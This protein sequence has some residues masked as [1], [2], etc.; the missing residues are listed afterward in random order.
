MPSHLHK[1]NK[2]S[3]LIGEQKQ[4]YFS[5]ICLIG[6]SFE[7]IM[8][9]H[10]KRWFE[11][12]FGGVEWALEFIVLLLIKTT[13]KLL[14]DGARLTKANPQ[15]PIANSMFGV[16]TFGSVLCKRCDESN[17][18]DPGQIFTNSLI[19]SIIWLKMLAHNMRAAWIKSISQKY[20]CPS[21]KKG[22]ARA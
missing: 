22:S 19:T 9:F 17:A 12:N 20:L 11:W 3:I 7:T 1:H 6:N 4:I 16:G 13:P 15:S 5:G 14:F 18:R 2:T 10:F 8:S 21:P